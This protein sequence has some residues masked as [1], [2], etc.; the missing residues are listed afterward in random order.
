MSTEENL[1][2]E[3]YG[4]RPNLPLTDSPPNDMSISELI[5]I[6]PAQ[7]IEFDLNN[8]ISIQR[9]T[10]HLKYCLKA[11]EGVVDAAYR[12]REYVPN[13]NSTERNAFWKESVKVF[14]FCVKVKKRKLKVFHSQVIPNL[15]KVINQDV[16]ARSMLVY[17]FS[18]VR[19]LGIVIQKASEL[20]R[21]TR[22]S[23]FV[24]WVNRNV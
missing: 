22:G 14:F 20:V 15:L 9:S 4:P 17:A 3:L 5:Q 2:D 8:E 6:N 23:Y 11:S 21:E 18:A 7:S 10:D 1:F 24:E 13:L 12:L 16:K 19:D